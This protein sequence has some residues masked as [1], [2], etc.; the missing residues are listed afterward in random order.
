MNQFLG[1]AA[2]TATLRFKQS[3]NSCIE[4]ILSMDGSRMQ[5][6]LANM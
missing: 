5:K 1:A 6:E 2:L 3:V 4:Q